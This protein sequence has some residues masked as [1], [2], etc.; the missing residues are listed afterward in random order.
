MN[1]FSLFVVKIK[2]RIYHNIA[3]VEVFTS[4]IGS[5]SVH[6][7]T[8]IN[9]EMNLY[10]LCFPGQV[11]GFGVEENDPPEQ[12]TS[13]GS[14]SSDKPPSSSYGEV[15]ELT[16]LP[17]SSPSLQDVTLI[18]DIRAF[19]SSLCLHPYHKILS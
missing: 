19:T 17:A 3:D 8:A 6:S 7:R 11:V 1:C 18:S 14:D 15:S 5:V 13:C 4:K 10:L 2:Q 12:S 16:F 9:V